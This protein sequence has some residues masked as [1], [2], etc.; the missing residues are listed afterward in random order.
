MTHE[1]SLCPHMLNLH[2]H[3]NPQFDYN[4][5]NERIRALMQAEGLDVEMAY[6]GLAFDI[7]I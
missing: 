3:H 4:V 7:D 2:T 5:Q 1:V 6:D